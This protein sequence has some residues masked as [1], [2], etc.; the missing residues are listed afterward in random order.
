MNKLNWN[1]KVLYRGICTSI[2]D[3]LCV[4][5]IVAQDQIQKGSTG[6]LTQAKYGSV[7]SDGAPLTAN[8]KPLDHAFILDT[9]GDVFTTMDVACNDCG[10]ELEV[11]SVESQAEVAVIL[12]VGAC[13]YCTGRAHQAGYQTGSDDSNK[14]F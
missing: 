12:S 6:T 11:V 1:P 10:T 2:L 4:M 14:G 7:N 8:D 13:S 9:E 5:S 3:A